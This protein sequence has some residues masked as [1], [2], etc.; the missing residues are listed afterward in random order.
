MPL[1]SRLSQKGRLS[2]ILH[3]YKSNVQTCGRWTGV[4]RSQCVRI[5]AVPDDVLVDERFAVHVKGLNQGDDVTIQANICHDK[6]VLFTSAGCFRADESGCVDVT[7]HESVSGNYTGVDAMGLIWSMERAPGQSPGLRPGTKD[8]S[9][10]EL[11]SL[12]VFKGHHTMEEISEKSPQPLS[13]TDVQRWYKAR[14]V[15]VIE[16]KQGSVRGRLFVPPGPGPFPGVIDMYGTAGGL[17]DSRA[18]MLASRGFVTLALAFFGYKDLPKSFWDLDLGYFKEAVHLISSHPSVIPD[19][20]GILGLSKGGELAQLIAIHCPQVRAVV[21][22]NGFPCLSIVAIRNGDETLEPA[23]P[24]DT[25]KLEFTRE[26]YVIFKNCVVPKENASFF[27]LWER[28]LPFLSICGSDDQLTDCRLQQR[29]YDDFPEEHKD[30]IELVLYKGAGHLIEPPFT[31]VTQLAYHKF[32]RMTFLIGGMREQ[33][34][35]AQEDAWNRIQTFFRTHLK[36]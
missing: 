5:T 1:L 30:K 33:H 4:T 31:P 9:T 11:V 12:A 16:V 36:S 15:E 24:M 19:G 34:A 10:P 28:D 25:S 22:I 32:F 6:D 17:V 23:A 18:A 27:P 2:R 8:V 35:R 14:E 20:I 13:I 7:K 26:N 3:V 21:S 29:Q